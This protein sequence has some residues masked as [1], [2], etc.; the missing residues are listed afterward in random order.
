[1]AL[2]RLRVEFFTPGMSLMSAAARAGVKYDT[3]KEWKKRGLLDPE[4]ES[5]TIE[6]AKRITPETMIAMAENAAGLVIAAQAQT[7]A[8]LENANAR[9]ASNIARQQFDIHQLA[10]GQATK[11]VEFLSAED[12]AREVEKLRLDEGFI[13]AEVVEEPDV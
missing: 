12:M 8:E 6:L 3:A 2:A 5:L 11:R 4:N 9:D 1:M 7:A 10:T 13:E